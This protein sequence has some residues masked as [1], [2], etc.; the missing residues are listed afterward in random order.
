M[1]AIVREGYRRLGDGFDAWR[2]R[3]VRPEGVAT[4]QWLFARSI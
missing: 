3:V 2:A 1:S 4:F